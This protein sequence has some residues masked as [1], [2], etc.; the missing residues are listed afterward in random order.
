MLDVSSDI[1]QLVDGGVLP[2]GVPAGYHSPKQIVQF[3]NDLAKNNSD[4][5]Q[6]IDLTK[7]YGTGPTVDG[8]SVLAIKIAANVSQVQ[9]K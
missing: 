7:Q 5:A 1:V 9:D 6:V 3:L 2:K 4:I 8:N